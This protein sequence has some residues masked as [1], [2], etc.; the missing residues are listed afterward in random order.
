MSVPWPMIYGMIVYDML[1]YSFAIL[2]DPNII[3][4]VHN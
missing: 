4:F 2:I 3:F 1:Y